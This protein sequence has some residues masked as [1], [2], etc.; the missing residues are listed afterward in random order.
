[1]SIVG[2]TMERLIIERDLVMLDREGRQAATQHGFRKNRS[3]QTNLVEFYD[4]VSRWLDGRDAVDVVYLDLSKAFD[5]VPHDILVEKLR[6]FGIHQSTVRWIRAGLTDQK[7]KVTISG[8]SSGWQPVTSGVPQ[9]SVLG[10]ILFNLF[11]NDMEEGVNS[12]LIKFADDTKTGAVA[13]TEE[14]VLQI[15]KD[16][17]RLWKW[18]GDTKMAFSVDKCK[19]LHLGHRNSCHK[20]R[21]E[22]TGKRTKG[23]RSD[24]K[25][26]GKDDRKSSTDKKE[27]RKPGN[28]L[29]LGQLGFPTSFPIDGT[30][31]NNWLAQS[32]QI[33]TENMAMS[34][35]S[36]NTGHRE[37]T[38]PGLSEELLQDEETLLSFMMDHSLK[39]PLKQSD[40]AKKAKSKMRTHTKKK[41]ARNGLN[42]FKQHQ[43][44]DSD[45]WTN[46]SHLSDNTTKSLSH[47]LRNNKME[48]GMDK[49]QPERKVMFEV[50]RTVRKGCSHPSPPLPKANDSQASQSLISNLSNDVEPV[51]YAPSDPNSLVKVPDSVGC[52]KTVVRFKLPKEGRGTRRS[53]NEKP[54]T[55][56]GPP[57]SEKSKVVLHHFDNETD[58]YFSDAEMSDSDAE[59]GS[60]RGHHSQLDSGNEDNFRMSI[61]AS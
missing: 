52:P 28:E 30:F 14:Q 10:P 46:V 16:L 31:F 11:I 27:K 57:G 50:K 56:N 53:Q 26:K 49:L 19:V 58:G 12:L 24:P 41:P 4:K 37:D 48:K 44:E 20:Y 25:R 42:F 9:G 22:Q 33:T 17:D 54:E 32:V 61:L 1:M 38:T 40:T 8:E 34:E 5:K 13:T 15:Q 60:G 55:V 3:C 51:K 47:D 6:S 18:A 43:E 35:W 7:Q 39:S 36:L 23:R 45:Q 2:K 59:S 21:L 29:V